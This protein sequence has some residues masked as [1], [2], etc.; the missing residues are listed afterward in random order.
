MLQ[1][2]SPNI[3]TAEELDESFSVCMRVAMFLG[4]YV[5]SSRSLVRVN[6]AVQMTFALPIHFTWALLA[7]WW[8][9]VSATTE[10]LLG[11]KMRSF[12]SLQQVANCEPSPFHEPF[13][14]RPLCTS[15]REKISEPASR[16]KKEIFLLALAVYTTPLASGCQPTLRRRLSLAW[17]RATAVSML[18]VSPASPSGMRNAA[19]PP[20]WPATAMRWLLWGENSSS[21][22]AV[23]SWSSLMFRMRGVSSGTVPTLARGVIQME[24]FSAQGRAKNWSF[25]LS[26][27]LSV[28]H[29]PMQMSP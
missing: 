25:A 10:E 14:K 5:A 4:S 29:W 7:L 19:T 26:T 2:S 17:M 27:V 12:L 24:P 8:L 22:I 28:E 13:V 6:P 16:S 9:S 3:I 20:S 15:G 1:S 11:S 21:L 23:R 18:A